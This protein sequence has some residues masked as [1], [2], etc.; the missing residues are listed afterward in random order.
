MWLFLAVVIKKFYRH[1]EVTLRRVFRYLSI[2]TIQTN[3]GTFFLEFN[4]T[5]IIFLHILKQK[6][7]KRFMHTMHRKPN[8]CLSF[9]NSR[10][11][12]FVDFSLIYHD[13]E[14]IIL[15][16]TLLR[17]RTIPPMFICP[18]QLNMFLN[19]TT[20]IKW[21]SQLHRLT[22]YTDT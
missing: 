13:I 7:E 10:K 15:L 4:T 2:K 21:S 18:K 1:N 11:D 9:H 20:I 16:V 22:V 3:H 8:I 5:F 17:I 6:N 19:I 12:L 14:G